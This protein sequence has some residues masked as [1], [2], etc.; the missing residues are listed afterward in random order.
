MRNICVIENDAYYVE[1]YY[2]ANGIRIGK[3]I[4]NG[5]TVESVNYI[6]DGNNIIKETHTGANSYTLEYYYDSNDNIV[7]FKYNNTKYLHLKNMKNDIVG[8]IDSNNNIVVKYFYDAYGR[9]IK[10]IDT[11]GN[12][13]SIMNP[14][15]YRSYYQDKETGWYYLNSR[16][17]N[18]ITNRFIAMDDISYL[19]A[20]GT[21]LSYNL[22]SYCENNPVN[23]V[24]KFGSFAVGILSS[25][26][27]YQLS[28]AL[29]GLIASTAS[30]IASIKSAI[31]TAWIPIL[32]LDLVA[33]ATIGIVYAVNLVKNLIID[34]NRAK[35]FVYSKV[36]SEGIFEK[37]LNNY[38]VYVFVKKRTTDVHYVGMTKNFS[39]RKKAH[40]K[41]KFPKRKFDMIPIV[42]GL[43]R[44]DARALEQALITAFTLEALENMINSIT[45]KNWEKF[46]DSFG[47]VTTLISS[48]FDGGY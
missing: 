22:L 41:G 23:N 30:T 46:T 8:I 11:S 16:Y 38:T 2:N 29:S 34:A 1:Y 27:I 5:T 45:M 7:G 43:S 39:S 12:N 25:S 26:L 35:S 14:F 37:Q 15:R 20:S 18:T 17:Y 3:L 48:N 47:R 32:V 36:K 31:A 40:N 19:W 28:C 10:T 21:V 42:T 33:V 4:D 9:I 13:L 24:D 6:L 44:A